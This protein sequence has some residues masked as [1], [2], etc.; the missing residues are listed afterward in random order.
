MMMIGCDTLL[1]IGSRFPYTEFLPQEGRARGV[2]IDLDPKITS[3]CHPM[4]VNL[5]GDSAKT[6]R[7]LLPL[8]EQKQDR[9]WRETI[10]NNVKNWWEE[11][12]NRAMHDADPLN[13]QRV[14][15]ELSPR[16]PE[17]CIIACDTG[18]GT[19][20]Y[21]RDVKIRRRMMASVSGSLATMGPGI[22]AG[23]PAGF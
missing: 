3:I 22:R 1:M 17:K 13:P 4:E 5:I 15:R 2:Q 6:L 14:F 16:L 23:S 8:L 7:K 20:W 18:S 19:N 9:S 10:E 11:F 12:K 21:A